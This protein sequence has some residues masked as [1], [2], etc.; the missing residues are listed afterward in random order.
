MGDDDN[1]DDVDDDVDG[2]GNLD[3]D[4]ADGAVTVMMAMM[5]MAAG[6]TQCHKRVAKSTGRQWGGIRAENLAMCACLC[7]WV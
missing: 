1:D 4:G 6:D 7:L 3:G 5:M 2:D